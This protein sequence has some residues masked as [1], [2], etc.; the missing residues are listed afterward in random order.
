ML[1]SDC[2]HTCP[3]LTVEG[4]LQDRAIIDACPRLHRD[5]GGFVRTDA[6]V[7]GDPL[8]GPWREPVDGGLLVP[9]VSGRKA[10]V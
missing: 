4:N 6:R 9:T 2:G 8:V 1:S 10:P 7:A 5:V 3:L